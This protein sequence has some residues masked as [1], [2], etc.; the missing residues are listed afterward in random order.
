MSNHM[1][2]I[3]ITGPTG[4][5]K[6]SALLALQALGALTLDCDEIYHEMLLSNNEMTA[7]IKARF[8][9][10]LTKGEIDRHKLGKLVWDYPTALREL[11][12]IT[13]SYIIGEVDHRISSFKAQGGFVAAID[14]IAL[15]E[16]GQSERC[17]IIVGVIA[18]AQARIS[19]I[20]KRDGL[21]SEQAQSRMCAQQQ[22]SYYKEK[23]D[24]ILENTFETQE[25]FKKECTEFFKKLINTP[26]NT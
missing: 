15:I 10:A 17:D 20:M 7:E 2:I 22:D 4:A 23:C 3:G 5:G 12:K 9:G 26:T 1:Y 25:A 14:A 6:T 21:T 18:P 16:S 19:R 8:K 13:H 11:N 24:Y